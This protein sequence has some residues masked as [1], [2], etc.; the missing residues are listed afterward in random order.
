VS[1]GPVTLDGNQVGMIV[2]GVL[3]ILGAAASAGVLR[4]AAERG[5]SR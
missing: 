5:T 3:I 4:S 2:G 1:V